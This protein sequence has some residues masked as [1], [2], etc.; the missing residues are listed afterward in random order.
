MN[1]LLR[2]I[3]IL[4]IVFF[5][6]LTLG[7][8]IGAVSVNFSP[9]AR[10]DFGIAESDLQANVV[11]MSIVA[12]ICGMIAGAFVLG[13]RALLRRSKKQKSKK[14]DA[15]DVAPV[16]AA[17]EAMSS[18]QSDGIAE[19]AKSPSPE[20]PETKQQEGR[21][22]VREMLFERLC[23]TNPSLRK[24]GLQALSLTSVETTSVPVADIEFSYKGTWS[25]QQVIRHS[26]R[27]TSYKPYWVPVEGVH[28]DRL[29][30]ADCSQ[31]EAEAIATA[32]PEASG[33]SL[34]ELNE[35]IG[36]S[37]ESVD[38]AVSELSV[39]VGQGVGRGMAPSF[40]AYIDQNYSGTYRLQRESFDIVE[41]QDVTFQFGGKQFSG[42]LVDDGRI[43]VGKRPS[44]FAAGGG[45]FLTVIALIVIGG[46][47]VISIAA[48]S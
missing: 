33:L 3:C 1:L 13:F 43:Y 40:E 23:E 5:G 11:A 34:A 14:A 28:K 48:S 8:V 30:F 38:R 17:A 27:S 25:G 31:P 45:I 39:R 20:V 26:D 22:G 12:A 4:L 46:I 32:K 36:L 21:S 10:E 47:I 2:I 41:I 19:Q 16:P 18:S 24:Q 7:L 37:R 6:Y 15:T 42:K 9:A 29:V 44:N 35:H